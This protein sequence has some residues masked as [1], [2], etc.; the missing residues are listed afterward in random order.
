MTWRRRLWSRGRTGRA[1]RKGA[2]ISRRAAC[3]RSHRARRSRRRGPA[4]GPLEFGGPEQVK[5]QCRDARGTRWLEDLAQDVRY[6][7]RAL[8][9]KPGFARSPC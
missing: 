7:L 2:A 8:R 4:A 9:Q 1:A 3:G 6:A 5:E